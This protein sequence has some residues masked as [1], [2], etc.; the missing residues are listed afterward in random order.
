MKGIQYKMQNTVKR[1]TL[2]LLA[3]ILFLSAMSMTGCG[4]EEKEEEDRIFT[5]LLRDSTDGSHYRFEIKQSECEEE[6][7]PVLARWQES[8]V[9]I[10]LPVEKDPQNMSFEE[11]KALLEQSVILFARWEDEVKDDV[12]DENG[13]SDEQPDADVS[14]PEQDTEPPVTTVVLALKDVVSGAEYEFLA[15]VSKMNDATKKMLVDQ[16]QKGILSLVLV[17]DPLQMT[18]EE[19]S[20]LLDYVVAKLK[21]TPS[22]TPKATVFVDAGHGYTNSQGVIDKGAGENTPYHELTGKYES[23][24]NLA[25]ALVLKEKLELA[26]YKVIMS[27]ESEVNEY[28]HINDRARMIKNSGAD[29]AVSIHC[30]SFNDLNVNGARVYWH[31]ENGHAGKSEALAVALADAINVGQQITNRK[32]YAAEGSY[33]VVRDVHIPSVLVET[34]FLTGQADALMVSD[35]AWAYRMADALFNGIDG[36][37]SK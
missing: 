11:R 8:G 36:D 19:K 7:L 22:A 9:R 15:D 29:F 34:C 18:D 27:R 17:K 3:L 21:Y 4:S 20:T 26:G 32:A 35:N 37:F 16:S 12:P 2:L 25:I 33:A 23:D 28:L 5:V 31:S 13:T 6:Y 14:P 10:T 24:V 30:N 1:Y